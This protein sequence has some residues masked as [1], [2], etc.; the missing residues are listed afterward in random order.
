MQGSKFKENNNILDSNAL[1]YE[2]SRGGR[3]VRNSIASNEKFQDQV[4]LTNLMIDDVEAVSNIMESLDMKEE[5]EDDF[6]VM[7]YDFMEETDEVIDEFQVHQDSNQQNVSQARKLKQDAEKLA[8]GFLAARA[9]TTLELR[10]K[11]HGKRF[12]LGIVDAIIKDL[13]SRGL[14][15]DSLYAESFSRSRW[16]SSTWGPR[17]IKQALH[18]KG[19][20]EIDA[21]KALKLVFQ[22]DNSDEDQ[23]SSHGLSKHSMDRLFVQVSKQWLKG[24]N[25]PREIQKSRIIRWLQYRGFNWG[26]VTF[27]LKKLESQYPPR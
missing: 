9:I 5:I 23:E 12:P 20:S 25:S 7:S 13:Q 3:N 6:G 27:I 11:L 22:E 21:E 15:N 19:V 1:R 2:V 24:T 10:K 26:V 4:P 8:I 17:R 14:I 18:K 16:S